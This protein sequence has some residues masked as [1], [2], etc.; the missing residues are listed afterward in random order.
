[1]RAGFEQ[2]FRGELGLERLELEGE[3]AKP[4]RLERAN[5]KLVD[6]LRVEDVDAALGHEAQAR[7]CLERHHQPVVAEDHAL[8]LGLGR[9]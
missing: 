6:A 2:A 1:M 4:A 7:P 8:D 5:V 9:P 3:V